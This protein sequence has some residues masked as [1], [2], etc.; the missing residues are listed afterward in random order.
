[1]PT[2]IVMDFRGDTRHYFDV[3]DPTSLAGARKRFM[4]L[5]GQG[6]TAAVRR[7]P[8][9]VVKISS[10]TPDAEETVFIPRLVGG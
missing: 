9:E 10:F 5:T 1:M 8:C 2:Q 3:N 7:G 6:F 4:E